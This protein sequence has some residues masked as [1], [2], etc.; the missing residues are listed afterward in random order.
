MGQTAAAI[1][2]IHY[3]TFPLHMFM[4]NRALKHC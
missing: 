1:T 4:R 2:M 3:V